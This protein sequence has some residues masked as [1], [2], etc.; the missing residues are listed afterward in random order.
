MNAHKWFK[1]A[2]NALAALMVLA[3]GVGLTNAQGPEPPEELD[4]LPV[5]FDGDGCA[6]LAIGVP[7]EAVGAIEAAGAVNVLNGSVSSNG[8]T[9][10]GDEIWHQDVAGVV[11]EAEEDDYFGR[12]LAV[13]DFDGDG[14]AD[15]AIGVP[16]EEVG[17][18]VNILYGMTYGL[19]SEGSQMWHQDITAIEGVAEEGDD[20]GRV[21]AVG[22]FDGDGYDDLA[23]G[24]PGESVLTI[25][26]AGAVNVIYGSVGGFTPAG[27]QLWHQDHDGVL[28]EAEEYDYFGSALAVGDFDGDGY[29][30]LAIGVP[31][32]D[33]GVLEDAGAVHVIYGTAG[34]L[35]ADGDQRW[36]QDSYQIEG[37]PEE[38]DR[39][40]W[41]LAAGD[42]DGDGYD[43]LA[44][45]VPREDLGGIE[46]VG[47]VNVIY[48]S[49]SM[50]LFYPGDQLWHQDVTDVADSAETEDQFG[51]VLA[52]DDFD[53]DG[54]DD[55]AVGVPYEDVGT[56][57]SAGAV[58][59][60]Y[61]TND[62]LTAVGNWWFHQDSTGIL[63]YAESFDNF[64]HALATGDFD[65]DSY[66]DLAIGVPYEDVGTIEDAG[67]ASVVYG[68]PS[69][70]TI[71][72]DQFW[73]QDSPYI[74]GVAEAGD[75]FG[76]ALAAPAMEIRRVYLPLV[77]RNY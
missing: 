66:A 73:H 61:G 30:D 14:Y 9:A 35:S 34:G 18:A 50:G 39:F 37:D 21:L 3:L 16:G 65:G 11:D 12:G 24:V 2:V 15:L 10:S 38:Y 57:E 48:G 41:A 31:Y 45:G 47:A 72:G 69:G 29:D 77:V 53:R 49:K 1:R 20:F 63:D 13:G 32:E 62:G 43:D 56:F 22:D 23:I 74:E 59:V 42:F 76:R 8:L 51:I 7:G 4:T 19:E 17:G 33:V 54:Y 68:S 67:A 46:N 64:G 58:H 26:D 70:L 71:I 28:D 44:I 5:G 6:D 52:A 40:G 55:L 27:D 36:S 25:E 60:F 75:R